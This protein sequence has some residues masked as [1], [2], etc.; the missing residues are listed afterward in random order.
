[1]DTR[2]IAIDELRLR[3][4]TATRNDA[5]L[6]R[7]RVVYE[8]K[9]SLLYPLIR[10]HGFRHFVDVGANYGFISLLMRRTAPAMHLVAIEPDPRLAVLIEENFRINRLRPPDVVN[11]V[12][13]AESRDEVAFALNP[14]SSPDNRV[15]MPNWEKRTLPMRTLESIVAERGVDGPC[16]YKIDTQGYELHVLRGIEGRLGMRTDWLVKLEFAPQ[17]LRSQGTD[18]LEL[19]RYLAGRYEVVEL[20]GR[21]PYKTRTLDAL[22]AD[23]LVDGELASFARYV[24]TLDRDERGWVD[25]LVRARDA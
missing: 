4:L 9:R 6:Y 20:P 24:V 13:G 7:R 16:F 1:M 14:Y 22:F 11:A 15:T 10:A 21:L 17:W 8:E 19:L 2:E 12:V 25:L 18:P 23:P 3:V 5:D